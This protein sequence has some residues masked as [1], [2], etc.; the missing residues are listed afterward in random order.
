MNAPNTA[1][2]GQGYARAQLEDTLTFSIDGA[3]ADTVTALTF[4][5][6]SKG[7]V[8]S[9]PFSGPQHVFQAAVRSISAP[10]A[11][12]SG[13]YQDG[14]TG[15]FETGWVSFTVTSDEA[16]HFAGFGT[17]NLIGANPT[18]GYLL[19]LAVVG[20]PGSTVDLSQTAGLQLGLPIGVSYTSAS[21]QRIPL[22]G[23][24]VGSVP[25]SCTWAMMLVGFGIM[26][27]SMRHREKSTAASFA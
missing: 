22:L 11:A 19:D 1:A 26:G 6:D 5:F 8:S 21:G 27:A 2:Y 4:A 24:P 7:T 16:G 10:V 15:T 25:E 23:G 20:G 3:T 17:Y 18:L 14:R 9:G 12:F 13:Q